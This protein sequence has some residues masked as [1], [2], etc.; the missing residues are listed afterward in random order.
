MAWLVQIF[1]F[2]IGRFFAFFAVSLTKKTAQ[3]IASIALAVTVTAT[4][5]AFLSSSL[6][7]IVAS[8][9][10]GLVAAGISLLPSN[11]N[12]CL[13]VVI[14][15]KAASWLYDWQVRLIQWSHV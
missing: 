4:F 1:V 15:V 14:T 5:F 9:P 10:G 12:A 13:A 7:S 8:A 11:T 3:I 2:L 6:S